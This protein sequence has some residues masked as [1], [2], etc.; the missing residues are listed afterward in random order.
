LSAW[1]KTRPT[2]AVKGGMVEGQL[3]G[4]A[5]IVVLA[6]LPP[7]EVLLARMAGAFQAPLQGLVNVLAGPVRALARALDQVRQQ[8][9]RSA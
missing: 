2:L 6:D 4:P 7:R 8:K 3:V 9:E 5:E 1:R